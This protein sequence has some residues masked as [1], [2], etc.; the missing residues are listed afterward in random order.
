MSVSAG[1]RV[2]LVPNYIDNDPEWKRK[3]SLWMLEAAQGRLNNVGNVSLASGTATT[4]VTDARAGA[5]SFIGLMPRTANAAD[6]LGN[7]TL[8]IA[9]QGDGTFTITHANAATGD[10]TFRYIILG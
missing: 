4:V 9:T 3:A 8:Y 6:E 10:R 2:S 7:G 1:L 5:F